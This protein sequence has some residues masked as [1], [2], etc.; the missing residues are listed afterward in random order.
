MKAKTTAFSLLLLTASWALGRDAN[1]DFDVDGNSDPSFTIAVTGCL[2]GSVL[3]EGYTLTDT[4][5]GASYDLVGNTE[6]LRPL[7]GSEIW[8]TGRL[9]NEDN[10]VS[11]R[12]IVDDETSRVGHIQ[13]FGHHF[14]GQVLRVSTATKL[15]DHCGVSGTN[16]KPTGLLT[17]EGL[18]MKEK[19]DVAAIILAQNGQ[20]TGSTGAAP[21]QRT[22]QRKSSVPPPANANAGQVGTASPTTGV[23][24]QNPNVTGTPCANPLA[25]MTTT[26][27]GGGSGPIGAPAQ[28][29]T[30][31]PAAI[32]EPVTAMPAP[33]TTSA[34]IPGVTM[35]PGAGT[36]NAPIP[37]ET[38]TPTS[39]TTNA[40]LPG[41]VAGPA[42]VPSSGGMNSG[43]TNSGSAGVAGTTPSA[44]SLGSCVPTNPA[45][46]PANPPNPNSYPLPGASGPVT[47]ST[48]NP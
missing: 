38:T 41:M 9:M 13:N 16:P 44:G 32:G 31:N 37:G 36:T 26:A 1:A 28:S 33:Q 45:P 24:A 30:A 2:S 39:G 43:N 11:G 4:G 35:S 27:A 20:S 25:G 8:V 42:A 23:A 40:P 48:P 12:T 18:T 7:I 47:A 29:N 10:S 17:N 21:R 22:G 6:N 46:V 14:A 15:V 34:P 3:R 19:A 5:S